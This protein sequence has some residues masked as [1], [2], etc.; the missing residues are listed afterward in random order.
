MRENR[1]EGGGS[2][3]QERSLLYAK[4]ALG[5]FAPARTCR[6]T[7]EQ[8][9]LQPEP[10]PRFLSPP[11]PR[12]DGPVEVLMVHLGDFN[13]LLSLTLRRIKYGELAPLFWVRNPGHREVK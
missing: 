10:L 11:Q 9:R 6:E 12:G 7:P 2:A 13:H 3:F 8:S 5:P 1:G 4:L